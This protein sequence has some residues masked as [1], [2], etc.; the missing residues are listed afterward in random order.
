MGSGR[1]DVPFALYTY[2]ILCGIK[3]STINNVRARLCMC[4]RTCISHDSN[5]CRVRSISGSSATMNE[6]FEGLR[7]ISGRRFHK[8]NAHTHTHTQ[9]Q[10]CRRRRR[11]RIHTEC[12]V[13][14]VVG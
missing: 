8:Q 5:A 10:Y 1:T 6:P 4:T 3:Y 7:H 14:C 13:M 9:R 2:Y 11:H 12:V